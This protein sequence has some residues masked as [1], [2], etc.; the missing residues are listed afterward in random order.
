MSTSTAKQPVLLPAKCVHSEIVEEL[1]LRTDK[2]WLTI[3]KSEETKGRSAFIKFCEEIGEDF[4][5]KI[6][7]FIHGRHRERGRDTG[8]GRSRLLAGSPMWDSIPGPR[9]HALS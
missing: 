2:L 4:F 9:D 7:L 1:Q 5:F 6:Y 8:R 3:C